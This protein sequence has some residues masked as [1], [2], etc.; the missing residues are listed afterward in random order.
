MEQNAENYSFYSRWLTAFFAIWYH[1]TER[2]VGK[3][4]GRWP[5]SGVSPMV[6]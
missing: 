2:R 1:K 6:H 3:A 4:E 5:E